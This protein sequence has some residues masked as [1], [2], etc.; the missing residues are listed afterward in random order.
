MDINISGLSND[1]LITATKNAAATERRSTTQLIALLA[2]FDARKLYLSQGCSSLFAYCTDILHLSEHAAYHRIE[3]ARAARD[4]PVVLE[5]LEGGELTLTAVGLLRSHLTAENHLALLD[6][7]RH[8]PKRE[9]ERL[10]ASLAPKT[11]I[12]P[13]TRRIPVVTPLRIGARTAPA[14]APRPAPA[15]FAD[16]AARETTVREQPAPADDRYLLRLTIDG[17]TRAKLDR[18][19]DLLRHVIPNGDPAVIVDRALTLLVEQ[20]ERS[21]MAATPRPRPQ[22][23][24]SVAASTT[25]HVPA[26]VRRTVWTRDEG[27]C[28]FAGA[29]GRCRE[30]G[31]LEFHHVTPFARGGRTDVANLTLRCRAHNAFEA[32]IEFGEWQ[33]PAISE[34]PG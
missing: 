27:R 28:T 3:A 25:R 1:Q 34:Q 20:L 31:R 33:P 8:R 24:R 15:L 23:G 17:A 16:D 13:L 14:G 10:V 7:A 22:P 12:P 21:K 2:E 6:A 4:F 19:R 32:R 29:E 26:A 18:A 5:R 11:D 30:T 9:V